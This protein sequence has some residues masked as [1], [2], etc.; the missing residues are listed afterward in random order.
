MATQD[1]PP[2]TREY[3][4]KNRKALQEMRAAH[5]LALLV[6]EDAIDL[7]AYEAAL[8]KLLDAARANSRVPSPIEVPNEGRVIEQWFQVMHA[9]STE[10]L[11]DALEKRGKLEDVLFRLKQRGIGED[12]L[13]TA[14]LPL[15]LDALELKGSFY[16][17]YAQAARLAMRKGADY[18]KLEESGANAQGAE[19]DAYFPFGALSFAQ[20]V[21]V[22]AQRFV[23]LAP[24][25][26][27]PQF[28]GLRDTALD[29]INYCA[30][31]IDWL[32]RRAHG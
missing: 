30:F 26:G 1:A 31:F 5:E 17:A 8:T 4:D 23:A 12:L 9:Y 22:K 10:G 28:E 11:L 20:M 3:Q 13:R 25:T 27:D 14:A 15:L 7:R 16:A 18:N 32:E 2:E 19:R 6:I 24:K 29:L 21:H